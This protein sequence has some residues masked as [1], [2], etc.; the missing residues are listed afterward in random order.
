MSP[1]VH[2]RICTLDLAYAPFTLDDCANT[3]WLSLKY[4]KKLQTFWQ[5]HNFYS[6]I[7][8]VLMWDC[9]SVDVGVYMYCRNRQ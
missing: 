4:L 2:I 7:V 1:Q 8:R 9:E 6:G 5:I 3:E